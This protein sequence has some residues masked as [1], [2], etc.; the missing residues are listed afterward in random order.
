MLP[1]AC[2]CEL[3]QRALSPVVALLLLLLLRCDEERG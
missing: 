3:L 2:N 1:T